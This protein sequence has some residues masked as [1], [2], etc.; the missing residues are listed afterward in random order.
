MHKNYFLE[1]IDKKP[2][3]F[4]A[5]L[6]FNGFLPA[7]DMENLP[8]CLAAFQ[9][10]LSREYLEEVWHHAPSR[11]HI[12]RFAPDFTEPFWDFSEESRCLALLEPET[13]NE[14][15]LFYGS[16]L[17]APEITRMI[18][19]KELAR[20]REV[21]GERAHAYAMQRGQYQRPSGREVFA[22]RH[23][24]MPL[25]ERIMQHGREAFG[26][27][28]SGWPRALQHRVHAEAP[29]NMSVSSDLQRGIWFDMKK[30]LIKEVAPAWAPCF[31]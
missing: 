15:A 2:I 1:I 14:L 9:N 8:D 11:K 18:M 25:A 7:K 26:I 22:P 17:H 28:A 23:R 19:G 6:R 20:L 4:A 13:A 5:M 30:I 12:H 31:A 10:V 21:L 29:V 27:I 3:L 16:S 24:E